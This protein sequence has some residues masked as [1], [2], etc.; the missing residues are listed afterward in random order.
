[1]IINLGS[2]G[3]NNNVYGINFNEK[4]EHYLKNNMFKEIIESP[5]SITESNK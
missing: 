5:L 2:E 1:V 4:Y 3:K